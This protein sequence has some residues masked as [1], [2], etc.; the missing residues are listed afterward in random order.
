MS[1][2]EPEKKIEKQDEIFRIGTEK[3]FD[4]VKKYKLFSIIRTEES[5]IENSLKMLEEH[6]GLK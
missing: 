4:D 2:N 6:F 3:I 1:L 5:T